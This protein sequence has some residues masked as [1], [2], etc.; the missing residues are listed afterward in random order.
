MNLKPCFE[1]LAN[2]PNLTVVQISLACFLRHSRKMS[3]DK[4]ICIFRIVILTFIFNYLQSRNLIYRRN[5]TLTQT[6][7]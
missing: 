2:P 7:D 1:G 6:R 5:Q 4:Q 3:C